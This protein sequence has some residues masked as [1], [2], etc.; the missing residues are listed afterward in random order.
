VASWLITAA[1]TSLATFWTRTP[2]CMRCEPELAV[3][4][5]HNA[6]HYS[7]RWFHS[8]DNTD[9][10]GMAL[11]RQEFM[12]TIQCSVA[13][14]HPVCLL[15]GWQVWDAGIIANRITT[16]FAGDQDSYVTYLLK[17]IAGPWA[18]NAT[19][20]QPLHTLDCPCVLR[21][22]YPHLLHLV[23]ISLT[24]PLPRRRSAFILSWLMPVP[25]PLHCRASLWWLW[26]WLCAFVT[27]E[28][29]S[30]TTPGSSTCVN[31]WANESA[32]LACTKA[33]VD[34]TGAFTC[35]FY[36]PFGCMLLSLVMVHLQQRQ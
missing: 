32:G 31:E 33:Y 2:T 27:A 29:A 35:V 13:L 22:S 12:D 36:I 5:S 19:G 20:V 4:S 34:Q 23:S 28:W 30:C 6:P 1:T 26:F 7:P 10:S 3:T 14:S 9:H 8:A 25:A 16:S 21:S 11:L 15:L 24:C 17:Q 18:A